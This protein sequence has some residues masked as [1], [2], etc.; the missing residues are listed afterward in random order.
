MDTVH[1]T[2]ESSQRSHC[3]VASP[4]SA[5]AIHDSCSGNTPFSPPSIESTSIGAQPVCLVSHGSSKKI[6]ALKGSRKL[7]DLQESLRTSG[8]AH[9]MTSNPL[10]QIYSELFKCFVDLDDT[11]VNDGALI[12]LV[13]SPDHSSKAILNECRRPTDVSPDEALLRALKE[14]S[15]HILNAAAKKHAAQSTLCSLQTDIAVDN[16]IARN[17][18]KGVGAIMVLPFLVNER[19]GDIFTEMVP[20]KVFPHPTLLYSGGNPICSNAMCVTCENRGTQEYG[21]TSVA[22][23]ERAG[24]CA[25]GALQPLLPP[26]LRALLPFESAKVMSLV[27]K[28]KV[29]A[30]IRFAL[31]GSGNHTRVA[32]ALWERRAASCRLVER[33][34]RTLPLLVFPFFSHLPPRRESEWGGFLPRLV[35]RA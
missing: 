13:V 8:F 2:M 23:R 34:W 27:A 4:V 3:S 6:V 15:E 29:G 17:Y 21:L 30:Q 33:R 9:L 5:S 7:A 31:R 28:K 12:N 19:G 16:R 32:A 26:R 11:T 35:I 25:G 22:S 24:V 10:I 14:F 1:Y 20:G 18:A